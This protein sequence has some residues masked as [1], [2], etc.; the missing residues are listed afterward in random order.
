MRLK[1][2]VLALLFP[3]TGVILIVL[4]YYTGNIDFSSALIM[5]IAYIITI[6]ISIKVVRFKFNFQRWEL[7]L[8]IVLISFMLALVLFCSFY[9]E[10]V[11]LGNYAKGKFTF[12]QAI[13]TVLLTPVLEEFFSKGILMEN[14]KK[15]VQSPLW[16]IVIIALYFW[17]LHFPTIMITHLIFGLITAYV[18]YYQKNLLQ[19]MLIHSLYNGFIVVF[20]HS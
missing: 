2:L 7:N 5:Y 10:K 12:L 15:V 1:L 11:F 8:K 4:L 14:L 3:L 13:S 19:V 18:Y 20:N 16:N 6:L 9:I 17:I